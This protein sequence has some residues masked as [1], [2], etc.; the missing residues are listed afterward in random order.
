VS[1]SLT[2]AL[3]KQDRE[4]SFDDWIFLPR[5]IVGNQG[6]PKIRRRGVTIICLFY[7]IVILLFAY[8][9]A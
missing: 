3:D 2:E 7:I 1:K 6:F 9:M 5:G 8:Y 4:K